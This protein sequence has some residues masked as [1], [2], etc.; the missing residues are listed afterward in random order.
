[1]LES[2]RLRLVNYTEQDLTFLESLLTN[3]TIVQFIGKGEVRT[4]EQIYTFYHWITDHYKLND[5]YGLKLIKDKLTGENIGHAGL[6]PQVV[7]GEHFIEVGYWINENYWGNGY[8]TEIAHTLINYGLNE[9]QL[10]K[11]IA[12]IQ[13]GNIAS[14][15]VAL[16]NGLNKENELV[17]N[18]KIV[19]LY[20]T[21]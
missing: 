2:K 11:I 17:L 4:K 16:K 18:E 20:T 10:S 21:S 13:K 8:A 7:E 3:P 12:L 14:E 15:K 9:L 19:S 1:M 5:N 6:V